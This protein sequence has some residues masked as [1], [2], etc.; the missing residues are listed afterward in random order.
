[1]LLTLEKCYF[2]QV[3]LCDP[4]NTVD[5][6]KSVTLWSRQFCW[7]EKCYFEQVLL[8]DLIN[9]VDFRKK[10]Y[11]IKV[12]LS[13][14]ANSVDFEKVLLWTSVTLKKCYFVIPT[15]LLTLEKWY[16]TVDGAVLCEK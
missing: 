1:M 5:F 8:G 14:P 7:L 6:E 9:T 4:T 16:I 12:L 3:F 11:F 2:E 10:W 13:D 15:I